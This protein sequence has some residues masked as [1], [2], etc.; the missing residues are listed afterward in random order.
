MRNEQAQPRNT[1]TKTTGRSWPSTIVGENF[2]EFCGQGELTRNLARRE[3]TDK[4]TGD[5]DLTDTH[6]GVGSIQ[7]RGHQRNLARV[8]GNGE[9]PKRREQTRNDSQKRND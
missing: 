9:I 4:P 8:Q 3:F 1:Q 7:P 6:N 5:R 2:Y